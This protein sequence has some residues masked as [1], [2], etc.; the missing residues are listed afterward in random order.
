MNRLDSQVVIVTGAAKGIGAAIVTRCVAEGATVVAVDRDEAVLEEAVRQIGELGTGPTP[1]TVVGDISDEATITAMIDMAL[2]VHGR[3]DG[4]VNNAGIFGSFTR[5]EDNTVDA[6]DQ[7][8]AVNVRS[9]WMAMKYAKPAILE[10]G[11]GG[12]AIVNVASMAAMRANRSLSLYGMTKAAVANLTINA[13]TEYAK[14]NIRVNAICPGPIDTDMLG[15]VEA[16][17]DER[18]SDAA[19][20]QISRSIPLG[21]YGTP[22]EIAGA[23]AFLLSADAGFMT[24]ALVPVDGG[25]SLE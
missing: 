12:G 17:I 6:F 1:S 8:M 10:S 5:F 13:A 19:R 22:A 2:N 15:N 18:H 3:L 23:A 14:H 16:F 11:N 20:Q 24:G 4:L 25:Q 9:A 21:R 7:M